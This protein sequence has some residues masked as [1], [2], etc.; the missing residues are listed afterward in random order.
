M[1]PPDYTIEIKGLTEQVMKLANFDV[2]AG[3]RFRQAAETSVKL[4]ERNWKII[5]PVDKSRY[6]PSIAGRVKS[7]VGANVVAVVGT[8]VKSA[9]GFPYPAA[10]E[11]G[12]GV[13]KSGKGFVYHYRRGPRRGQQT[14]G[15]V[16]RVLKN[17]QGTIQK[18]FDNAAKRIVK[19]LEI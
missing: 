10:L 19:D 13:R 3:I 6:R 5:A 7:V 15:R 14:G 1:R 18:M 11:A 16:K 9:K 17:A 4:L 12:S 8:N 2:F